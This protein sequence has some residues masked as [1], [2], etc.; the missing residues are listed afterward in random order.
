MVRR[1]PPDVQG[2]LPLGS[3]GPPS[4]LP[5]APPPPPLAPR[6]GERD[7]PLTVEE[8][9][10]VAALALEEHLGVLWI[11][12]EVSNLR[13]PGSGHLYFV[14]KDERAQVP[15]VLWRSAAQRLRFRLEDGKRYLVRGKVGIY[16]E[17]G[18]FQLYVE[19]IEP[20][21]LG[22]AALA[23]EQ[24]KQRLAAEGLFDPARKRPLPRLP[25]RIGVV[26]S[27]TG[28]A[29]RDIIRVI[30]RRYP[31][32]ILVSPTR[33]QGEG[34]A[35]EIAAAIRRIGEVPGID[36]VIV[37]RGGGSSEDLS[38]FNDEVVVRAIAA[39]PVPVVSAVGHEIDVTL[40]DLAA[41][42][43]AATPTAAGEIAVPE[44][45]V[46]EES[47][48]KLKERLV[49]EA[50]LALRALRGELEKL[51]RRLSDPLRR[52]ERERQRIDEAILRAT[53]LVRARLAARRQALARKEADLA[54][55]HPQARLARHR[56]ALGELA[57]RLVAAGSRD[58]AGRRRAFEAAAG[59]LDA[60][61]PL[62][63]LERGYAIARTPAGEV[64][65]RADRVRP[66]DP[67]AVR[68]SRG[69]LEVRV[70]QV[71]SD[72]EP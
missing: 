43:R 56:T 27:P 49:R 42:V 47:L 45:A 63:V 20:V 25:R 57:A 19:A 1:T 55:L 65:A 15:A 9:V 53:E 59:R 28:A 7:R 52:V 44:R 34:A 46:L 29:V 24:L 48:V 39:C 13:S 54:A 69:E 36:L 32:P 21:G 51:E 62:K 40:A 41:D 61:S 22:A 68:L 6:P 66:G 70:E 18:K 58:L 8:L 10:R 4:P 31:V 5:A 12:G 60:M 38:A 2:A 64:I 11:E 23:L 35:L 72:D 30:E 37:G 71:R 16:P 33:V 67:L 50:R 14:L 3:V 26:T 17:Q